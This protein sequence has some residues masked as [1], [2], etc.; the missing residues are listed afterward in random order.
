VLLKLT[1]YP[2]ISAH[3]KGLELIINY[4]TDLPK[5]FIGDVGRLRQVVTN[6]VGNAVKFT[7]TGHITIDVD[8]KESRDIVVCTLDVKDTGIGISPEKMNRIFDK[9]T[10]ADGSTTR[11]YGGT[12]LGLTISKHIVEMMGGRMRVH[13]ELGKG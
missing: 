12:G 2:L 1:L 13:S 9:F 7:D 4:P 5:N 6:L 10:Q 3:D 11:V 8:I